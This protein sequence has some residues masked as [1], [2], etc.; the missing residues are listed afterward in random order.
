MLYKVINWGLVCQKLESR[1]GTSN[2]TTQYLWVVITSPFRWYLFAAHKSLTHL[3]VRSERH[4]VIVI[5]K[6]ALGSDTH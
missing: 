4:S 6:A 3:H 2:Y 1:A 5:H